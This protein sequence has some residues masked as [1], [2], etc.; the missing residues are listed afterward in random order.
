[1]TYPNLNIWPIP[2]VP[3]PE[4]DE[5]GREVRVPV[6]PVMN[7]LRPRQPEPLGDLRRSDE[8]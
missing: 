2:D 8:V 5:R 3:L 1:M 6:A 7:H 4:L